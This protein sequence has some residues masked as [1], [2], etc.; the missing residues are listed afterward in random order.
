[1]PSKMQQQRRRKTLRPHLVRDQIL[2]AMATYG[3]PISPAQLQR[4]LPD[5]S[6]GA[7]AYHT[8][9]L[10][11]AGLIE[12]AEETMVRGAVEHH[13]ALVA[14]VAADFIDPVARLQALCGALM[15]TDPVSGFPRAIEPDKDTQRKLLDF[16]DNDVKPR[17]AEILGTLPPNRPSR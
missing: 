12:L 13:Y 10:A 3:S 4:A 6:L 14:D 7:V 2:D 11:S 8:R 9:V 16:L 15:E 17:V 5:Q 1:M